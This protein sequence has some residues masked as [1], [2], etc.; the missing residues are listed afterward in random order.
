MLWRGRRIRALAL[1]ERWGEGSLVYVSCVRVVGSNIMSI[2]QRNCDMLV[3][4]CKSIAVL[5]YY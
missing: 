1:G 5:E 3:L 4:E 2:S